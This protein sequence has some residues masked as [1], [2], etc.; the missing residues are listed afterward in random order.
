MGLHNVLL[1][2]LLAFIGVTCVGAAMGV[3]VYAIAEE[4]IIMI[5]CACYSIITYYLLRYLRRIDIY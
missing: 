2:L 1:G 5:A 4:Y 3:F